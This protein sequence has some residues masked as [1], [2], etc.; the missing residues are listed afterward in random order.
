MEPKNEK[1]NE[2]K[3]GRK[4]DWAEGQYE[5]VGV[6]CGW[7]FGDKYYLGSRGSVIY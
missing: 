5:N 2:R 1:R 3:E 7:N 4:E 6:T